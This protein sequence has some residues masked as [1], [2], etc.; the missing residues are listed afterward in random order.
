[1][2]SKRGGG[3][4]GR[5]SNLFFIP[6]K[7]LMG[8]GASSMEAGEE[9]TKSQNH[10]MEDRRRQHGGPSDEVTLTLL[11]NCQTRRQKKTCVIRP[12]RKI[13]VFFNKR[14]TR[15]KHPINTKRQRGKFHQTLTQKHTIS[16]RI[17]LDLA[18]F[19]PLFFSF[20]F[21]LFRMVLKVR[22]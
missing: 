6:M 18:S 7:P 10:K 12:M 22:F 19:F 20:F 16:L 9:Q 8:F 3:R 2:C 21:F 14:Q 11:R 4:K 15:T 17:T 1:M 13:R 5:P